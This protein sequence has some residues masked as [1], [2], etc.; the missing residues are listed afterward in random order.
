MV[1]KSVE[2]R[3][4]L[5][6]FREGERDRVFS[7]PGDF[8]IA[9]KEEQRQPLSLL[10]GTTVDHISGHTFQERPAEAIRAALRLGWC[11]P[12]DQIMLVCAMDLNRSAAPTEVG[13]GVC[14]TSIS[15]QTMTV[16]AMEEEEED[17]MDA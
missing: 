16:N 2:F 10:F 14:G 4:L 6:L 7:T 9:P 3:L 15:V 13:R 1:E 11:A 17:A 5:F 8:V 12:G